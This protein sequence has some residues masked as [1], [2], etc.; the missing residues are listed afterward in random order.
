MS[1]SFINAKKRILF[2]DLLFLSLSV[3]P[4][5][6]YCNNT[7]SQASAQ[8]PT[9]SLESEDEFFSEI[10]SVISATRIRQPLTE[11]PSSVTVID[12]EMIDASGAIEVADVLRLVPGVQVSYPQGNQ[13]A[14]AYHGFADAFPRNMQ[15]LVDGRS[16][17]QPSFADVD[18]LF[19]GVSIENIERIEVVRGPNSPLYGSNAVQG[20]INIITYQPYQQ[21][22]TFVSV[23]AGDLDTRNVMLRFGSRAG[24]LDYRIN[25]NYQESTG[26][27][28]E[29]DSTDDGRK[30]GGLSFRGALQTSLNDEIDIQFGIDAGDLGAGAELPD[31]PL[32]HDKQVSADFQYI[33]WRHTFGSGADSQLRFYRNA[34]ESVDEYPQLLSDAFNLS[35]QTIEFLL[36]GLPDQVVEFGRYSYEGQRYD[37][38]WQYT[39][40]RNGK[41]QTMFGAGLRLNQVK[42]PVLVGE[43]D[44]I[45]ETSG[46]VFANID[47]RP[48]A[49]IITGL[50]VMAEDSD[51]YGS[52]VS[53]RLSINYLIS[54][55]HSIRISYTHA[56]RNP[57]LLEKNFNSV[58]SLQDG[59][60]IL[61]LLK[62]QNPEA[63][64]KISTEIG[65]IGYWLDKSLLLDVK[66]F[67]E[68]TE[69]VIHEMRSAAPQPFP[70]IDERTFIYKNDGVLEVNG[71][72]M[73]M[74][75]Q[76]AAKD[77]I[78]V[79]YA[80]ID[81][82][83]TLQRRIETTELWDRPSE[84]APEH[85]VSAI[86]SHGFTHGFDA[87]VA[88]YY[89]SEMHWLGDGD[90]L[91]SYQRWDLR[92][93][94][95][96][97]IAT[98]RYKAEI[99]AQNIG[100]NY[101]TFRKENIFEPRLYLRLS[102]EF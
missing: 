67:N 82:K 92:L 96:G 86:L 30:M 74:K 45:K 16:I 71:F 95:Q 2:I 65:F 51:Q 101:E 33:N 7:D 15:V 20:V 72:E 17:Y 24:K 25:A 80:N 21:A 102:L 66:L 5:S 79:Q 55:V 85:T 8:L 27:P 29:L 61:N 78:S 53:P 87:S 50:G 48:I 42:S 91:N 97:R 88:F 73:Q 32:A 4:A 35:P 19:L 84:S 77:F 3:F 54:S 81:V 13:I 64:T 46:R 100:D 47:Y 6:A 34:Y 99:L 26:L 94:K 43:T 90:L 52:Y 41:W 62:S 39:S 10:P 23:T 44:W 18:W 89:V 31:D 63:E 98:N 93:A 49:S 11:A 68:R 36:E 1:L 69:D 60:T 83:S 9:S 59:T 28:G 57:S 22:G 58:L 12:R 70:R 14:V 38:E 56:Q 37:L 40:A 76:L 75:Y